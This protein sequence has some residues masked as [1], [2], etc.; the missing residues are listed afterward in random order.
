MG[1]FGGI[2]KAIGG[3]AKAV[4]KPVRIVANPAIKAIDA[5]GNGAK[6]L[7]VSAT[8]NTPLAGVAK[9]LSSVNLKRPGSIVSAH[10]NAG[11]F[12][13]SREAG[14]I[15]AAAF[16]G[17]ASAA[18]YAAGGKNAQMLVG[19][20][21]DGTLSL[22]GL[23]D[24]IQQ[25]GRELVNNTAAN[26]LSAGQGLLGDAANALNGWG[27]IAERSQNVPQPS[28]DPYLTAYAPGG[29]VIGRPGGLSLPATIGGIPLPLV[30]AGG[31]AAVLLLRR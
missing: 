15:A 22:D 5:A 18:A 29:S 6:R 4:T 10:L 7:A 26:A 20:A 3:V 12:L 8:K 1:L 23:G 13:F 30:L 2:G 21:Q 27:G 9:S 17:G 14:G 19:A 25:H 11:K 31:V 16:T 24:A 28:G